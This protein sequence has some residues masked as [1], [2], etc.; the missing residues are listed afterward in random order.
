METLKITNAAL[1]VNISRLREKG[2]IIDSKLNGKY[3][4]KYLEDINIK[5][6][7]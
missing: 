2:L 7:E 4:F 1:N 5:F 6:V 3:L